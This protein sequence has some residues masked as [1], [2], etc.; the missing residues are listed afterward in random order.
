MTEQTVDD[1]YTAAHFLR[2]HSEA[3]SRRVCEAAPL[4]F[5]YFKMIAAGT[6]VPSR[7]LAQNLERASDGR[8]NAVALLTLTE[9]ARAL[10]ACERCAG[11]A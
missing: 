7:K 2:T 9:S 3:E 8:M 1:H 5:E 10:V 11:R 4:S 6:Y